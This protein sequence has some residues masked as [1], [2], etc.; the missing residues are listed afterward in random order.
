M[1]RV[2]KTIR[3]IKRD[4][5]ARDQGYEPSHQQH[6]PLKIIALGSDPSASPAPSAMIAAALVAMSTAALGFVGYQVAKVKEMVYEQMSTVRNISSYVQHVEMRM[7]EVGLIS[8]ANDY[9]KLLN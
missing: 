8:K 9:L 4:E 1:I 2:C 5:P 6:Q 7:D 3:R